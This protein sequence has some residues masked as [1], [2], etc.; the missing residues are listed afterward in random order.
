M[1]HEKGDV[2]INTSDRLKIVGTTINLSLEWYI[3]TPYVIALLLFPFFENMFSLLCNT[4]NLL[5]LKNSNVRVCF[6]PPLITSFF[7]YTELM[8]LLLEMLL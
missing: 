5:N 2:N 6:F 3:L 8:A 4:Y 7:L 1:L